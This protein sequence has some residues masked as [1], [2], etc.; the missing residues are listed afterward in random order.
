MLDGN[1][2]NLFDDKSEQRT[3]DITNNK[4]D[5]APQSVGAS[6]GDA[7]A[8]VTTIHKGIYCTRQ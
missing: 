3:G 5:A 8:N 4:A 2:S 6:A 7:T 1:K